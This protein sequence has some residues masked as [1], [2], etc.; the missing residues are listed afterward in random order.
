[1]QRRIFDRIV[2]LFICV[3]I[4]AGILAEVGVGPLIDLLWMSLSAVLFIGMVGYLILHPTVLVTTHRELAQ[5]IRE[6]SRERE[7]PADR[8]LVVVAVL[9]GT[10]FLAIRL[11]RLLA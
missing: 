3:M 6:P 7:P 10:V 1:M 5:Q 9:L 11:W 4:V 8:L 2:L